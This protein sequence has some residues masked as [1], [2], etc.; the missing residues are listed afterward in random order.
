MRGKKLRARKKLKK[1]E[2]KAHRKTL[3]KRDRLKTEET[4]EINVV[5]SKK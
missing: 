3:I 5:N 2:K 4:L 1:R